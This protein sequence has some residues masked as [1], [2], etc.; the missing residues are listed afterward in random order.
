MPTNKPNSGKELVAYWAGLRSDGSGKRREVG[1]AI[2]DS[3]PLLD[4]FLCYGVVTLDDGRVVI[5]EPKPDKQAIE[6]QL[7]ETGKPCVENAVGYAAFMQGDKSYYI[8][9]N[10]S[11]EGKVIEVRFPLEK[12]MNQVANGLARTGF[13]ADNQDGR[14]LSLRLIEDNFKSDLKFFDDAKRLT[15]PELE[16][17]VF[18]VPGENLL[19]KYNWLEA[20]NTTMAEKWLVSI[21]D[22]AAKK[23]REYSGP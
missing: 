10:D 9:A 8:S 18:E 21:R 4:V 15:G 5:P 19:E 6:A 23:I 20:G 1:R 7:R 13:L 3:G 17:A 16:K 12:R 2:L 14:Y 11:Q 22:S